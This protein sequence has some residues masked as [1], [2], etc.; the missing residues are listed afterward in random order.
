MTTHSDKTTSKEKNDRFL[1]Q[2]VLESWIDG[3][4]VL[5]DQGQWI[6]ANAAAVRI[7]DRLSP[8]SPPYLVPEAIWQICATLIQNQFMK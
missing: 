4:L 8:N 6:Q 1:L 5:N 2:A 7:C 3:V